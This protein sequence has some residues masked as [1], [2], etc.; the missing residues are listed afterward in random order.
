[1]TEGWASTAAILLAFAAAGLAI[2]LA[3]ALLEPLGL[4]DFA[5]MGQVCLAIP[6]LSALEAAFAR[7]NRR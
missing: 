7:S 1:M 3:P 4:G 2:G 6:V 5:V